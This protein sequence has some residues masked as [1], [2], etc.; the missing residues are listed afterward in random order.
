MGFRYNAVAL[1]FDEQSGLPPKIELNS[2]HLSSEQII[3]IAHQYGIPVVNRAS[4]AS[5][6]LGLPLDTSIPPDLYEIV[7]ALII[8]IQSY[9][10]Q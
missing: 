5:A 9:D 2:D 4:L 7:A 10:T 1:S 3:A 8:E 6:L